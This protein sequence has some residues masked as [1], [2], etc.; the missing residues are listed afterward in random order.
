M[1]EMDV[2]QADATL[3]DATHAEAPVATHPGPENSKHKR[4]YERHKEA[5]RLAAHRRYF[6]KKHNVSDPPPIRQYTQL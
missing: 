2:S 4:F 6:L 1:V 3:A 5:L